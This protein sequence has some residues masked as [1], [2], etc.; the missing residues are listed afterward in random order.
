MNT[1][2]I[3]GPGE[4]NK[5]CDLLSAGISEEYQKRDPNALT[6][7]YASG[8]SG[9]IFVSGKVKSTAD[10][11]V[12]T[13]AKQLLGN[14][15][16]G[17]SLE[18]FIALETAGALKRSAL[19]TSAYAT[20]ATKSLLPKAADLG[21]GIARM[22]EDARK[23]NE[24]WFWLSPDY[25]V[26]IKEDGGK[27]EAIIRVSH[28]DSVR[29]E[30]IRSQVTALLD[31]RVETVHVNVNGADTDMGLVRG[32]GASGQ[33]HREWLGAKLPAVP[34]KSGSELAHPANIGWMIARHLARELVKHE[35]GLAVLVDLFWGPLEDIPRAVRARNE[36]G[37][38]ISHL[39]NRA[40]LSRKTLSEKWGSFRLVSNKLR[41]PF[42]GAIDLP[43]ENNDLL[44]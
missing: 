3:T 44:Q 10:F 8:G 25:D 32:V 5:L 33:L 24:G 18:P 40:S 36:R 29:V 27:T 26:T 20:S 16:P 12:S 30:D 41:F 42:D 43:F 11:D 15:D 17:L 9:A 39:I 38:D 34:N 23:G 37:K 4:A 19:Q 7:I 13:L 22:L 2:H 14:I 1:A 6:D 28:I 35:A 21:F 31:G